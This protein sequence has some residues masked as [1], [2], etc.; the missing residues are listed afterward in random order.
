[1]QQQQQQHRLRFKPDPFYVY[2]YTCA[3][4]AAY[5]VYNKLFSPMTEP[6]RHP[7][8]PFIMAGVSYTPLP[9]TPSTAIPIAVTYFGT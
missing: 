3:S 9:S 2:K 1:M 8:V 6:S 7:Q 5:H 4:T